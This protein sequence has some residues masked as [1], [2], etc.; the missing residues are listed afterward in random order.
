MPPFALRVWRP[1]QNVI[2]MHSGVSQT[3]IQ[4]L[5]VQ[6]KEQLFEASIMKVFFVV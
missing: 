2:L 4:I 6:F 3:W 5:A 1:E